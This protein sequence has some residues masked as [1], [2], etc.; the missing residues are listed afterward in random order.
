MDA[1]MA[2]AEH[3]LAEKYRESGLAS[4]CNPAVGQVPDVPSTE[5]AA[6]PTPASFCKT[7]EPAPYPHNPGQA[8]SSKVPRNAACPCGSGVKFKRCCGNAAAPPANSAP[9]KAA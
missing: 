4:F 8:V 2:L 9:G 6:P 3:Q 1:L 7:A 5:P